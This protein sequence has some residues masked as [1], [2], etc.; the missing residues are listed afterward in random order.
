MSSKHPPDRACTAKGSRF[1]FKDCARIRISINGVEQLDHVIEYCVSAGWARVHVVVNG[2]KQPSAVGGGFASKMVHG[3][4]VVWW[5]SAPVP[6]GA[7]TD[8]KKALPPSVE[9]GERAVMGMRSVT[10]KTE[11]G[12]NAATP[13]PVPA[14]PGA[15]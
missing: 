15:C 3:R 11:Q 13:A 14:D 2:K 10:D 4:V 6:A 9:P 1:Y 5:A 12:D 8:D 7:I